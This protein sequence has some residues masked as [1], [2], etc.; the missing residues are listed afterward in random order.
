MKRWLRGLTVV[1]GVLAV[2]TAAASWWAFSRTQVVPEFY[3]QAANRLPA[4][5]DFAIAR[6]ESHVVQLQGDASVDGN[7]SAAFTDEQINA[8]LVRELPR[9]FPK[10]LPP[11]TSA[12]RVVIDDG[13][14]LAAAR[15]KNQHIDTV[16]SFEVRAALTAQAN[17]LALR[18][19]N[20]RAGALPLPLSRFVRGISAEAKKSNIEV[21]WDMDQEEPIALVTI[22]S[23]HP[24]F[25]LSPV[26]VEALEMANGFLVLAG[27]TGE[28]AREEFQPRGP[29]YQLAAHRSD[30]R[31][32]WG[33]KAKDHQEIP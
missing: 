20:L 17:I 31:S 15:F 19:T 14:I 29:I 26:V 8:W 22:P 33:W 32:I 11:G 10:L 28:A 21:N 30:D 5:I 24:D 16:V 13:K 23:E 4:D 1:S 27:S 2:V 3:T 7:W 6:L 18:V 9:E 25:I 12:P